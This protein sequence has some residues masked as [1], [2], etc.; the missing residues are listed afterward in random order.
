MSNLA[1]IA[2]NQ[3]HDPLYLKSVTELGDDHKLVTTRDVCSSTGIKLV[4]CGTRFDSSLYQK[5]LQHKLAPPLDQCLAIENT[6]TS[7][8]L[9][10]ELPS[11]LAQNGWLQLMQS[12]IADRNLFGNILARVPLNPTVAFKLTVMREKNPE[13]F[14]HSLHLTLVCIYIGARHGLDSGKLA[15]LASAAL[16][17]DIGIL[18]ID[19]ALLE[20]GHILNDAERRHLYAHPLTAWMILKQCTDYPQDVLD[21]VLQHHERLDGSGYPLGRAGNALDLYGRILAVAEIISSRHGDANSTSEKMRLEAI[22]K[23]NS[24][25][26]GHQLIGYLDVF[27]RDRGQ[28]PPCTEASKQAIRNQLDGILSAI[29]NWERLWDARHP[30]YR[31]FESIDKR[32]GN[33]K[34]EMLDA[35][36]APQGEVDNIDG[37]EETP[38]AC[39]E[40]QALLEEVTWQ[41]HGILDEIKRRWPDLAGEDPISCDTHVLNWIIETER[42]TKPARVVNSNRNF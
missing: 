4:S 2:E 22:L 5:L 34:M 31:T 26:Y 24:R 25:R 10:A 15:E 36:I 13:L 28:V 6:V 3:L 11:L 29:S 16:L 8:S 39:F 1:E 9:T 27:Y 23:L 7:A 19:P 20:R 18:H 17:H 42:T 30:G 41:L 21:A 14:R 12:A 33:L 37:I 38:H 32:I 35:G 40:M